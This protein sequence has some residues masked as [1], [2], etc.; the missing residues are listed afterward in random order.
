V[1]PIEWL[2][3]GEEQGPPRAQSRIPETTTLIV[4]KVRMASDAER[5]NSRSTLGRSRMNCASIRAIRRRRCARWT[6]TRPAKASPTS[7]WMAFRIWRSWRVPSAAAR[8]AR[9]PTCTNQRD[10]ARHALRDRTGPSAVTLTPRACPVLG[11]SLSTDVN[12]QSIR[13]LHS[14]RQDRQTRRQLAH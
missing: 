13:Q 8:K 2:W 1:P 9:R 6:T 7:A 14:Y 10:L 5:R 4:T 3:E 12:S 11:F